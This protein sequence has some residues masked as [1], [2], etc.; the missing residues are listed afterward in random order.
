MQGMDIADIRRLNT[1]W[2]RVYPHLAR[3]VVTL[4]PDEA[5]K[6]LEFGPF[7]GGISFEL[8]KSKQDCSIIIA[9]SRDAILDY[10]TREARKRHLL[11]QI[12]LERSDL[13]KLRFDDAEFDAV[14]CRGAFFFL[15][16]SLLRE[17][18]RILRPGGIGF[19]GGGFGAFTPNALIDEITVESKRL[20]DRL[21]KRW[22]SRTELEK[23]VTEADLGSCSRIVE[24]GGLWL[25]LEK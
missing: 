4:L 10:L 23:M 11:N 6:V 1:L 14:I 9:D 3:Q 2:W 13:F 8:A 18:R 5:C 12:R 16:E 15:N 17:F 19:I 7:S 24:D 20:N 21:G 25:V 22:I